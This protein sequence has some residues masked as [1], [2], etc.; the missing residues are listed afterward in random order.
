MALGSRK[1]PSLDPKRDRATGRIK[2]LQEEARS[3][4]LWFEE[5]EEKRLSHGV[6][7][8]TAYELKILR[9]Q[10]IIREMYRLAQPK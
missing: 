10:R 1:Y 9:Y 2:T 3:I 7:E 6:E 4:R 5:Y 8:D